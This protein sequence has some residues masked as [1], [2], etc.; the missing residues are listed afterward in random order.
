MI[1]TEDYIETGTKTIAL[2]ELLLDNLND[3]EQFG[4]FKHKIKQT[5][6]M[7]IEEL[8]KEML[9]FYTIAKDEES[10]RIL[11]ERI[12]EIQKLHE[13]NSTTNKH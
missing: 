5:G 13:N 10:Q 9:K 7:F 1:N 12:K 3:L 11:Y 4:V 6:K 2:Y 8:S